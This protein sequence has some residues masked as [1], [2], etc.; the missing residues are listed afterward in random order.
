M[1][2]LFFAALIGGLLMFLLAKKYPDAKEVGRLLFFAAALA[3]LVALA[4]A[5]VRLLQGS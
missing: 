4:P 3:F 2:Y 5:A 1:A